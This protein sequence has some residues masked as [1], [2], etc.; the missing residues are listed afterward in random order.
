MFYCGGPPQVNQCMENTVMVHLC[1]YVQ[2]LNDIHL[3]RPTHNTC[4]SS[5]NNSLSGK[6]Y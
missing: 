3:F 6:A 1:T 2:M 4:V 5:V